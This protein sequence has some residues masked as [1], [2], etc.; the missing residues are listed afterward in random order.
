MINRDYRDEKAVKVAINKL[1]NRD[2]VIVGLTDNEAAEDTAD[3][4][5]VIGADEQ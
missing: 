2:F 5:E 4:E 3:A 1:Y